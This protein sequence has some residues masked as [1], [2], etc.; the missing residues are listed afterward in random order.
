MTRSLVHFGPVV[1]DRLTQQDALQR[2]RALVEAGSGGIVVTPNVD[3]IVQAHALPRLQEAYRRAAL[4]LADG[5]PLLW[6]ARLLRRPL[7]EKVSGSDFIH[8]L[9]ALAAAEGW[10]VFLV[11]ARE[12]TSQAAAAR[13]EAEHP[14]L[15][16]V[17][18]DT[19][20]WNGLHAPAVVGAIQASGARIVI[21]ALGCPKQELWMLQHAAL[22]A[23]AV[24]FGLGGT[25]DFLAGDVPRAPRWMSRAGLEWTYRLAQDPRRLAHRYL[26]RDLQIV[27]LFARMLWR[28]LL[29]RPRTVRARPVSP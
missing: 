12:A 6:M 2:V 7:P 5:Q 27:P 14:G 11:G 25:L 3:H 13:L 22:A 17:G 9:M 26:V 23:P 29:H 18:R 4:S 10:G 24:C 1:A 16:V 8:P 21:V 28:Q 15:R 20:M 19:T